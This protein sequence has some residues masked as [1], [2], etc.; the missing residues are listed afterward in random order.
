[1]LD[2]HRLCTPWAVLIVSGHH[3]LD[4]A[5]S[6]GGMLQSKAA[7]GWSWM[8]PNEDTLQ[9]WRLCGG[10]SCAWLAHVLC[11]LDSQ[12]HALLRRLLL[13]QRQADET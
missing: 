8:Q 10:S 11:L 3:V 7:N 13:Q 6:A 1:M 5:A 9:Y 12:D 2:T 4:A